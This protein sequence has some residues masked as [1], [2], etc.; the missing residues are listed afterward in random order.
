LQ[1]VNKTIAALMADPKC[2]EASHLCRHL[3]MKVACCTPG[4]V[5]LESRKDNL[6]RKACHPP[7]YCRCD[8]ACDPAELIVPCR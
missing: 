2:L 7:H 5:I 4:H 6:L 3:N 1:E 8:P